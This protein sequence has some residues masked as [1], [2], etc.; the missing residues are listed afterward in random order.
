MCTFVCTVCDTLSFP[1]DEGGQQTALNGAGSGGL[2]SPTEKSPDAPGHVALP[3]NGV[4][5]W[6]SPPRTTQVETHGTPITDLPRAVTVGS[7][8]IPC[9]T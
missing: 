6:P 5:M 3:S 4:G 1:L 8:S 2:H 7:Y 9:S